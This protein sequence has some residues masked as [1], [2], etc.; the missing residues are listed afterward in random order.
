MTRN[1][2]V[3][4]YFACEA[5]PEDD[6]QLHVFVVPNDMVKPYTSDTVSVIANFR[7]VVLPGAVPA[8]GQALRFSTDAQHRHS[9][10]LTKLYHLIGVGKAPFPTADRPKAPVSGVSWW[11]PSNRWN[12]YGPNPA[13]S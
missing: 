11:N 5:E 3:A 8:V 10:V 6:G 13:L 2:L 12:G 4:L 7:Q 9:Q 1:P